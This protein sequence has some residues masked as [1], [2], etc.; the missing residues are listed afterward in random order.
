MFND[1]SNYNGVQD[2]DPN[3]YEKELKILEDEISEREQTREVDSILNTYFA[4][5]YAKSKLEKVKTYV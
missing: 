3:D 2:I 1:D 4:N 5:N